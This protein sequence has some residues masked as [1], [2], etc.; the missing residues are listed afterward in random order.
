MA[1]VRPFLTCDDELLLR[2]RELR[3]EGFVFIAGVDEAGRGP[4]AG[5]VVA[6]AVI[7]P[8]AESLPGVFDSK[9][10]TD[11]R[12]R[13]LRDE[14]RAV[15]AVGVGMAGP[16]EI[17]EL[18]ILKATH[19]AMH[20]AV[21]ELEKVEFVLVDGL[22][23]PGFP[24]PCENMIKGDARCASIA[25]AS[26][27]AK[28]C[29]DELMEKAELEFPGYGFARHKGYGTRAHLEALRK[30]GVSPIHRRSFAPVRA[31]LGEQCVQMELFR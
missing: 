7:L 10:L 3:R 25:A 4:L 13:E 19:L 8:E 22:P 21:A 9:Q 24:C 28:V 27:V 16:E 1:R 14:I 11:R 12:R 29:R 26:I 6:A 18:N 5:P 23:V 15:A 17:D 30:L 20:R 31:L 2:E